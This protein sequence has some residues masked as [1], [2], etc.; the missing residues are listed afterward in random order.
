MLFLSSLLGL[1][2]AGT[3]AGMFAFKSDTS[4]TD[5][6]PETEV[7]DGSENSDAPD[8]FDLATA[9]EMQVTLEDVSGPNDVPAEV[10]AG[11]ERLD[12]VVSP[13]A[14]A[15]DDI[16][17]GAAQGDTIEGGAGDD[18]IAGYEGND[19]LLGGD[20]RDH[21]FG[22]AGDDMLAGGAGDDALNG[23]DGDD[24][25]VAEDGDD[26]LVG[27]FGA[28]T[29]MGGAGSDTLSGGADGDLLR[30][31]S[32]DDTLEGDAGDDTL[33]G[34]QGHDEMSGGAGDDVILGLVP[35]AGFDDREDG[36][37]LNGGAGADTLVMGSGDWA[38]GGEDSDLFTLG[39]W[40]D[41]AAPA[42]IADYAQSEDQIAIVY[43][44]EATPDPVVSV[45]PSQDHE[46]ASWVLL[47]GVRLAEVLNARDLRSED[48]LLATPQQF[49]WL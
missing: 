18:Q 27:A 19:T 26:A 5:T 6:D 9:T 20:G 37:L 7:S 8:L 2:V 31:G 34:D 10:T 22:D 14:G 25:L 1:L 29:L 17:W 47:N 12:P 38:N 45:E 11:E 4:E 35:N 36:D 32:G 44:P 39:E 13:S 42:T 48:V 23:G 46:A 40:I 41:P 15:G 33:S 16:V 24:L 28:D 3:S 43:D 49:A 21:L 30:G